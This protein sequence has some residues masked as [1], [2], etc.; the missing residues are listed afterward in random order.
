MVQFVCISGTRFGTNTFH[1]EGAA[2]IHDK[3]MVESVHKWH[4]ENSM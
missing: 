3:T 1:V 4:S 2:E